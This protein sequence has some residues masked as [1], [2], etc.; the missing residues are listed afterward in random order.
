MLNK[1][2]IN[3]MKIVLAIAVVIIASNFL[4]ATYTGE[5]GNNYSDVDTLKIL[6]PKNHYNIENQLITTILSRY[7][8]KKVNIDDSLSS[9]LSYE[10]TV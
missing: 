1:G 7:H 3:A 6:E 2:L 5:E 8:Y 9:L 10:S 4:I